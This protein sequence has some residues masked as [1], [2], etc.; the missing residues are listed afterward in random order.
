MLGGM[1][2]RDLFAVANIFVTDIVR[3]SYFMLWQSRIHFTQHLIS[4]DSFCDDSFDAQDVC[5]FVSDY[6]L[7]QECY[8]STSMMSVYERCYNITRAIAM[9]PFY[10]SHNCG[11]RYGYR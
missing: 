10:Y 4:T 5:A 7:Y 6:E 1:L 11:S 9:R 3:A 2:T 8:N